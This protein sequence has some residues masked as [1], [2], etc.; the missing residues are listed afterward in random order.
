[1]G[2]PRLKNFG[3]FIAQKNWLLYMK[4]IKSKLLTKIEITDQKI[5]FDMVE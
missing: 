2:G 5:E 3:N 4:N 1:M